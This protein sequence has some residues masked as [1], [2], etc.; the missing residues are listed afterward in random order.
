MQELRDAELAHPLDT[1]S[2][3]RRTRSWTE[4]GAAVRR[5]RRVARVN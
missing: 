2:P 4:A 3:D 1:E 5:D